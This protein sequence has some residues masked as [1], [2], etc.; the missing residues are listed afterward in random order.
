MIVLLTTIMW[1]A[2]KRRIQF[3]TDEIELI[4]IYY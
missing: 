1:V 2:M 3:G 4:T